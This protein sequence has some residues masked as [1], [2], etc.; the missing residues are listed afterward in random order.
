MF[1]SRPSHTS[2]RGREH[3]VLQRPGTLGTRL[4]APSVNDGDDLAELRMRRRSRPIIAA[5]SVLLIVLSIAVASNL[6]EQAGARRS[7]LEVA[8]VIGLGSRIAAGD[9]VDVRIS[10]GSGV[11]A[12]PSSAASQVVGRRAGVTVPQGSLLVWGDVAHGSTVAPGDAIVGASLK[13]GQLPAAGVTSGETV[14][15]ILAPP[16]GQAVQLSGASAGGF[17]PSSSTVVSQGQSQGQG[18]A[19]VGGEFAGSALV[20]TRAVIVGVGASTSQAGL[21]GA[22]PS[23]ATGQAV[24]LEVPLSDAPLIAAAAAAG[25]VAVVVVAGRQGSSPQGRSTLAAGGKRRASG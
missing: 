10:V 3:D 16:A 6:Y 7:V 9:L 5:A 17:S 25:Q 8:R 14:E 20:L 22:I 1:S 2:N 18:L 23:A 15:V 11:A 24:S 21:G 13:S 12:V 19:G 4:S